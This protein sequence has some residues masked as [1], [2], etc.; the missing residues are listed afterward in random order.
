[1][2]IKDIQHLVCSLGKALCGIVRGF[3]GKGIMCTIKDYIKFNEGLELKLYKCTAGK[4]SCGYGRNIENNGISKD[5]AELMLKNDIEVCKTALYGIFGFETF[6]LMPDRCKTVL[7]DMIYNLG[8]TRF[9]TFKK[10][11]KAVKSKDFLEAAKQI[12]DSRYYNQVRNRAERN[13]NLMK[14][15]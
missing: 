3:G 8:E 5:E 4:L 14:G 6:L 10:M 12:K 9:K 2:P 1:M 15:E 13:I 7:Y 11:V